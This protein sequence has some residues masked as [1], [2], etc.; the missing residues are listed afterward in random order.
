MPKLMKDLEPRSKYVEDKKTY[1]VNNH[2]FYSVESKN[3]TQVVTYWRYVLGREDKARKYHYDMENG[4]LPPYFNQSI[5][6]ANQHRRN[7][8]MSVR[9]KGNILS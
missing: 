3:P 6:E 4:R 2:N 9:G 1:W 5:P 8:V 7:D